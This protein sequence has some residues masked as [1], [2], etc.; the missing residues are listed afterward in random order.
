MPQMLLFMQRGFSCKQGQDVCVR[1]EL[2]H[3]ACF[4]CVRKGKTWF[5]VYAG[6]FE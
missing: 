2:V 3:A 6:N 5:S 4:F 1:R